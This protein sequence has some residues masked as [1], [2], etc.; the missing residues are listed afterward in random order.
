MELLNT[1]LS[2]FCP[3]RGC[4][5]YQS[6]ENRIIKYGKYKTKSDPIPR[7]LLYCK[8]GAHQFSET[9]YSELW[10][11]QGSFKEDEQT[12][13]LKGYALHECQIADVLERDERT[14]L[15]WSTAISQKSFRFHMWLCSTVGL[16]IRF[17]QMD[18]LWSYVTSKARQFWVFI[19]FDVPTRFWIGFACGKRTNA[20]AKRLVGQVYRLGKWSRSRL[21]RI[22]TDKLKAYQNAIEF[23]FIDMKYVYLQIVKKR[24]RRI[25]KTVT[26][27]FLQGTDSDF[28]AKT[29]NT[30]FIERFNL[31]LRQKISYL[32]RKTLGYCKKTEA[33]EDTL[34]ISLFDYNYRRFHK[35]LRSS[36][37]GCP[38][39][40]FSKRYRLS[41]PAMKMGLTQ[42]PL[43]WRF[44][45]VAPVPM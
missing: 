4:P 28:P 14:I 21:L 3:R 9:A 44:L 18:E 7:Q 20:T 36:L 45:M 43:T 10:G 41:T 8:K 32:R 1:E 40:Q 35:S 27:T 24:V 30:S 12:A 17:L 19:A 23:Y 38:K 31:T 22:T 2:L 39:K 42:S 34:A 16:V 29:Q 33:F 15:T 6:E 37:P 13:K 25:L 26:K 11:K 5:H